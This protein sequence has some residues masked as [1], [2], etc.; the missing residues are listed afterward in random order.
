MAG[1]GLQT[2]C[3]KDRRAP[4]SS[5]LP[6]KNHFATRK[7]RLPR[8]ES[9]SSRETFAI[10]NCLL[11]FLQKPSLVP[12][13]GTPVLRGQSPS[14]DWWLRLPAERH[15]FIC[16]KLYGASSQTVVAEPWIGVALA[17]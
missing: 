9:R 7:S 8:V 10:R 3:H 17:F 1:T 4:P 11:S 15:S 5:L 12:S 2:S 14:Q 16:W 6:A 13:P